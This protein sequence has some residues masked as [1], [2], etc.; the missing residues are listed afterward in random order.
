MRGPRRRRTTIAGQF[1]PRL[2][3]MLK[4]PAHRVLSRSALQ[5]LA[6][7]EIELAAHGGVDNGRLP[8][9]YEQLQE[10]GMDR[11]C[12][13]PAIRELTALGFIEITEA[14]RGGNAEFRSPNLF[15]LTFRHTDRA[16]PTNEWRRI[17]S[18][19][20]AKEIASRAR[21]AKQKTGV[22]FPQ[23]SG[24]ETHTETDPLSDGKPTLQRPGGKPPLP[25]YLG[26]GA[27]RD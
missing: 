22:G 8:T 18:M 15:R 6:R 24:W 21:S 11:S 14:G 25:L 7:L 10:F 12:I 3:E 19:A 1:A 16:N 23:I 17:R 13:A 20:E 27:P 4:S 2:I 9:T 5:I 26:E